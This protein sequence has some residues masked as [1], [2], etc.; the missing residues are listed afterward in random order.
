VQALQLSE[1]ECLRRSV[2][3][4]DTFID[5]GFLSIMRS[6]GKDFYTFLGN[7]DSMH[8]NFLGSFPKMKV[9]RDVRRA[10]A[11]HDTMCCLASIIQT[12]P[13]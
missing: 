11:R 5:S 3:A 7:L 8:D 1:E 2:F 10:I 13:Q 4:I 12:H 6:L 9:G